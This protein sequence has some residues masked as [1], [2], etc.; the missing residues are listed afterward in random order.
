MQRGV[1]VEAV[2]L[3]LDLGLGRGRRQV[4]PDRLDADL[5]A[6]LVLGADVPV[7]ARVVADQDGAEAGDDALLAQ[8]G[9][10]LG[11]LDLD[12]LRVAEPSSFCAV[13]YPVSVACRAISGRSAACR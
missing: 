7:R 6:V 5:G 2:D 9:H 1:G 12:G 8:P 11:Q 13:T 10:A 4:D 3:G